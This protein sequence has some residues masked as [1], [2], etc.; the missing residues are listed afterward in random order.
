MCLV[1]HLQRN[2]YE[3][4]FRTL[5]ATY[6]A[7]TTRIM[8]RFANQAYRIWYGTP[9][10]VSCSPDA[11][12]LLLMIR[13]SMTRRNDPAMKK[14]QIHIVGKSFSASDMP[15]L[16]ASSDDIVLMASVED[17]ETLCHPMVQGRSC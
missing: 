9:M 4:I 3:H 10:F 16:N 15:D 12:H 1:C 6:Q 17:M 5:L 2:C 8:I 7:H 11:S 13:L 14:Q